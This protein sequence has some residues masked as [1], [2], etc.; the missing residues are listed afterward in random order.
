MPRLQP[1]IVVLLFIAIED[2]Y[3]RASLLAGFVGIG[4]AKGPVVLADDDSMPFR[5][6]VIPDFRW[7]NV[8]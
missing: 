4:A 1:A 3:A 2:D 6:C 7:Q 8:G 5:E